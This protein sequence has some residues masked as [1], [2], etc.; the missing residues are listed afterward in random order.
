MARQLAGRVRAKRRASLGL[1]ATGVVA[2]LVG[3]FFA[4]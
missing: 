3:L 4:L 2:L 1:T